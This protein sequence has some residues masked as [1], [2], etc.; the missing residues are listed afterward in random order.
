MRHLDDAGIA[1]AGAGMDLAEAR[2]PMVFDLGG[3]KIGVL[4]Y[5]DVPS[6]GWAWATRTAPGTAPLLE[7]V[8]EEDIE[9][10]RPRVD[11][12]PVMPH[13]GKE[14]IATPEPQQVDLAHTAID[15]GPTS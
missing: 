2:K 15:A 9:R 10:L 6:Y 1:H 8:M 13:W 5:L 12:I 11:L 14:Y 7:N 4:S 3:T